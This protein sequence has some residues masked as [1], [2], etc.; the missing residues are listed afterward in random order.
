MRHTRLG[1]I[2]VIGD[3]VCVGEVG[4]T[5]S[6]VAM[7][8]DGIHGY[9]RGEAVEYVP[10]WRVYEFGLHLTT[11]RARNP[12]R[13]GRILN[14]LQ[15]VVNPAFPIDNGESYL[16]AALRAPYT[17]WSWE[18]SLHGNRGY[19]RVERRIAEALVGQATRAGRVAVLGNAPWM[20]CCLDVLVGRDL[21]PWRRA[22]ALVREVFAVCPPP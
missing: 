2:E 5:T 3:D 12:K 19:R 21:P 14:V 11:I 13:V 8:A 10:W 6:Y 9:S 1:P 16:G 4:Q 20:R 15:L 22:S 18:I 7:R 17:D